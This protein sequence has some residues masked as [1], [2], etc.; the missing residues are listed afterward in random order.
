MGMHLTSVYLTE[1]QQ[2]VFVEQTGTNRQ[3]LECIGCYKVAVVGHSYA[4]INRNKTNFKYGNNLFAWFSV[5]WFICYSI[6]FTAQ[7]WYRGR[8]ESGKETG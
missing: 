4:A 5:W 1:L 7:I 8:I 6:I 3:N 2:Y